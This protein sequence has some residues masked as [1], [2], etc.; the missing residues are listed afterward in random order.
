[1]RS[2][3]SHRLHSYQVNLQWHEGTHGDLRLAG[4]AGSCRWSGLLDSADACP[5]V[6]V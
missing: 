6:L 4:V 3:H 2:H 5:Q 1:M